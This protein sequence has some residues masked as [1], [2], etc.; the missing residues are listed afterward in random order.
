MLQADM[1]PRSLELDNI[2]AN[3]ASQTR[4]S[5]PE[6][7]KPSQE[8]TRLIQQ[9]DVEAT[10]SPNVLR[11]RTTNFVKP[12]NPTAPPSEH[13]KLH[14]LDSG[15][16]K[17]ARP[18]PYLFK[19]Y[20]ARSTLNV[21]GPIFVIAFY[22]FIF[23]E[24]FL[25]PASNDVVPPRIVDGKTTFYTWLVLSI[26]LLDWARSAVAGFEAA[27]LTKPAL[28]PVSA[29]QLMWHL[30]RSWGGLSGW[31]N[32]IV[33]AC[34]YWRHKFARNQEDI[35]WNGP[36]R[37]WWYLSL[38][39]FVLYAAV[40]LA[41]LSMDPVRALKHSNRLPTILGANYSTFDARTNAQVADLASGR[42]RTGFPTTPEAPTI[43][44]APKG[45]ANVSTTFFEDSIQALFESDRSSHYVSNRTIT[46]FS[47][48]R[49]AERVHGTAWGL[50]TAVSC[51]A[52]NIYHGLDLIKVD[53]HSTWKAPGLNSRD[54]HPSGIGVGTS[55]YNY[56]GTS[57]AVFFND[58]V[59]GVSFQYIIASD[60]NLAPGLGEYLAENEDLVQLPMNG[61][62]ELAIWQKSGTPVQT[63]A[64]ESMA[65]NA[66][67]VISEDHLGYGV[68][69]TVSSDI[70]FASLDAGT[71]T[72]SKFHCRRA[73]RT[74][75]LTALAL[76]VQRIFEYPGISAIQTIV[77][78]ALSGITPGYMGAPTCLPTEAGLRADTTCS[79]LYG[80]NLATGGIPSMVPLPNDPNPNGTIL[81]QPLIPPERM[82]L[83][84]Y[85]IFGEA[86]AAMLAVGPSNWTSS[87]LK[88][89]D[90]V[91]DL[92][93]GVVPWQVV[94]TLLLIWA[95]IT[96][97]PQ[98][99]V[100]SE[101][102]WSS[103][104]EAFEMFRF[105]A[106]YR[107]VVQQFEG[108][109]FR[110]NQILRQVPGMIG[111]LES[112]RKR[113]FVGLSKVR[114]LPDRSYMH[115]RVATRE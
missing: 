9:D 25:R 71:R 51:S 60:R 96:V 72:Y 95:V 36:G 100:F 76:S 105:G 103:T 41:G 50:S 59:Y 15:A 28:A 27:A 24:Y 110:E 13:N 113:G 62:F 32:V 30:D 58:T 20:L 88:G 3:N 109:D 34:K 2:N 10:A 5:V 84:M 4:S 46:F 26:F 1:I 47:G 16:A 73:S 45:T 69:C 80:A 67:V 114:A 78:A 83:A 42:W 93:I 57:P 98:L 29:M 79:L 39:S 37:L 21:I 18:K 112:R 111:D 44:Y 64:V 54:F 99:W 81:Q 49:I 8:S 86:A 106:E 75:S 91:N 104:L 97:L 12:P 65:Q 22:L 102:R 89:L 55:S 107:E 94:V 48:P 14:G 63:H 74:G 90:T 19:R 6:M 108:N 40:P 87:D 68:R 85:K 82:T 43:F 77:L 66:L 52:V 56:Y 7:S 38:S 70:G 115:D 11:R 53:N 33:Y 61:S 35:L 92:A 31:W 17:T 101:K 23:F